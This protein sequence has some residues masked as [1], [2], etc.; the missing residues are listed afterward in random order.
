MQI[1]HDALNQA[2]ALGDYDPLNRDS[3]LVEG[4]CRHQADWAMDEIRALSKTAGRSATRKLGHL[5][6]RYTPELHTHDRFGRRIDE[7]EFHPAWH[8]L[9][10]LGVEAEIHALPWNH[11]RDGAH[12]ARI[13]KHYLFSQVEAGV[14][15][16]LTMTF[17]AVPAMRHEP[18]LAQS[19]VPRLTS[20]TYDPRLLPVTEKRGALMGMAMTEKQGGSDVRANTT[21]AISAAGGAYKLEGH[22]WFCS[23]PMCDAFLTLAYTDQGLTCFL[24]PRQLDDGSRNPFHIQRLK[25]KLGNRSNASSE[26]EYHGTWAWRVGR[27]GKGIAT[28]LDMVSHT[29][30]DCVSGSAGMMRQ[31]LTQ[32]LHHISHRRAFGRRLREQPLMASVAADLAIES[33][34][35]TVLLLRLAHAYDSGTPED[36]AFRRIATAIAKY[37][38]CK[39]GIL[40][41]AE[42]MEC[43]GGN[44]YVE[45]S[46]MP[47]LYREMPVNSIWE[48]SGNVM[49]LDV[50]RALGRQPETASVLMAEISR[51]SA[52]DPRLDR[53]IGSLKALLSSQDVPAAAARGLVERLAVVL[54]AGL[55]LRYSPSYVAE[56]FLAAR[57]GEQR[58]LCFGAAMAPEGVEKILERAWPDD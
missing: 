26:I 44:G 50:L 33:E 48:G 20:T 31:A 9:M 22:K 12:V 46:I 39:R 52:M 37:W 57:L 2:P 42:A 55:L 27:E 3:A 28:I 53:E 40:L 29:R 7:V 58:G 16:P 25:D 10:A 47:R 19:W 32:A 45:A 35:A 34:A 54:Q 6:N 24:V 41:V 13:A 23:A 8:E 17:S 21:R 51:A 30:L 1:T 11:P 56:A 43:L 36:A 49:C 5:A 14:H 38:V 15:C 4:I 18:A